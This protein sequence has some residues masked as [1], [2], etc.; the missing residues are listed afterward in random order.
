[1]DKLFIVIPAYNE[2]DTI[3]EVIKEWHEVA[4]KASKESRLVVIDDGSK[5]STYAIISR[6]TE[7]MPRLTGLAKANGGH[8]A[9]VLYGYNYALEHGADY[10]FQTDSDG[11]TTAEEFWD[12][13]KDREKYDAIIG[14]RR[15]RQ[16]GF[17]RRIISWILRAILFV[18][19]S[20]KAKDVNT[21]FRLMRAD[22]VKEY[23]AMIPKDYNLPNVVLTAMFLKFSDRVDYRPISFKPRQGGVNSINLKKIFRI[24]FKALGDF[25]SI[26]KRMNAR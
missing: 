19:F 21:P 22:K 12:F 7:N 16:D 24:G 6:L 3:E 9:T 26:K 5:D 2:E 17:S 15:N 13:W 18:I 25:I 4:L 23:A 11:Q 14:D 10:I 20:V 1:M 8:G